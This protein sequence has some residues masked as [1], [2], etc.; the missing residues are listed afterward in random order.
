M[1][2]NQPTTLITTES[3]A[4]NSHI[5]ISNYYFNNRV[6]EIYDNITTELA[7]RVISQLIYLD[8]TEPNKPITLLINSNGGCIDAGQSIIDVINTLSCPINTICVNKGYSMGAILFL[9][10][11]K[12]YM[13]KNATLMLHGASIT[14]QNKSLND[15]SEIVKNIQSQHDSYAYLI[16]KNTNLTLKE[17][18]KLFHKDTYFKAKKCID[19]GFAHSIINNIKEVNLIG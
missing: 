1:S 2:Y 15:L 6:I 10:G 3:A 8:H 17:A 16:T 13:F 19:Y 7:N 9:I 14:T 11:K 18:N 12:R 5:D 4:G